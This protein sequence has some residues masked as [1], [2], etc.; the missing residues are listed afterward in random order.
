MTKRTNIVV[1][2][3]QNQQ[4]QSKMGTTDSKGKGI[5][6]SRNKYLAPGPSIKGKTKIKMGSGPISRNTMD[7]KQKESKSPDQSKGPSQSISSNG[8]SSHL[9]PRTIANNLKRWKRLAR[10]EGG[11]EAMEEVT[12]E[13]DKGK[14]K[15]EGEVGEEL[16]KAKR[17]CVDYFE[18]IEGISAEA[19][20]QPRR[21]P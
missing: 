6:D 14:R 4:K 5:E 15:T 13:D 10:K 17:I 21:T 2:S 8:V 20:G 16:G 9:N 3:S 1:S 7:P 11:T 18:C 19:V 12:Q